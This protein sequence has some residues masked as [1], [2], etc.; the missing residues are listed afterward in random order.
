[1]FCTAVSVEASLQ[2]CFSKCLHFVSFAVEI[3]YKKMNDPSLSSS[4]ECMVS[5]KKR[6]QNWCSIC[7]RTFL[8]NNKVC[9]SCHLQYYYCMWKYKIYK[10]KKPSSNHPGLLYLATC[11][12]PRHTLLWQSLLGR[13]IWHAL[14]TASC[15]LCCPGKQNPLHPGGIFG[16]VDDGQKPSISRI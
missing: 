7:N 15:V 5:K 6:R 1:L 3:Q 10:Q 14:S 2:I 12:H 13:I 9:N 16:L 4:V 8:E 11:S